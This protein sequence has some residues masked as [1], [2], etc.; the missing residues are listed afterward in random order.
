MENRIKRI[1]N[2]AI[3]KFELD[4]SGLI[5]FTEAATGNYLY[6]PIIAA[7]GGA[8]KVYAITKDSKYGKKETVKEKTLETAKLFGIEDKINV[9]YDKNL[10]YIK[11]CDIITNS[12]FVRPIDKK[13]IDSMKTTAVIPLMFETWEFRENDLDLEYCREKEIPVLGTNENHDKLK[14]FYSNGF[15]VSKLLFECGFEVYKNKFLIIGSGKIGQSIQ[16]F[17]DNNMI[18]YSRITCSP[19]EHA[20]QSNVFYYKDFDFGKVEKDI[21]AVILFEHLHNVP[22]LSSKGMIN[23]NNIDNFA[24]IPFIHICGRVDSDFIEDS[25]INIYPE[26]FAD[27]GYMTRSGDYLGPAITIELITAGLKVG[28]IMSKL[29]KEGKSYREVIE[30]AIKNPLVTSFSEV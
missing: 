22:I 8:E 19:D 9:V 23:K 28:E 11:E 29:R 15:L 27:F 14:L 1:V 10:E 2:N 16:D 24:D 20:P 18:E 30:V 25:G 26:D 17:F 7:L 4:L 5:I 6:T 3:N 21:D 13:M 12:G